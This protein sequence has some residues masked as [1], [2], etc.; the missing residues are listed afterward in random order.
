MVQDQQ[1]VRSEF[2]P[3]KRTRYHRLMALSLW[4]VDVQIETW[5]LRDASVG[6]LHVGVWVAKLWII[7]DF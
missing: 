2:D 4:R 5:G 7:D 6:N 3:E 1:P